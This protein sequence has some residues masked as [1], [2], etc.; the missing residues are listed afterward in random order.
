MKNK[1]PPLVTPPFTF[2]RNV[3]GVGENYGINARQPSGELHVELIYRSVCCYSFP[4]RSVLPSYPATGNTDRSIRKG[5]FCCVYQMLEPHFLS[6]YYTN[7]ML[8]PQ[9][10]Y[11]TL[12]RPA[13]NHRLTF[14]FTFDFSFNLLN[15]MFSK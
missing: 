4:C 8:E 5:S 9:L 14:L 1:Y 13:T 6:L 2:E 7:Q 15:F 11:S 10:T 3:W 12:F